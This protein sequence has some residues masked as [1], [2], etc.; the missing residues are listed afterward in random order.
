MHLDVAKGA[1]FNF[2]RG[3]VV[4]KMFRRASSPS[5]PYILYLKVGNYDYVTRLIVPTCQVPFRS[6]PQG[7]HVTGLPS[8][9]EVMSQSL[10]E[11]PMLQDMYRSASVDMS[12]W[13]RLQGTTNKKV[14]GRD[15]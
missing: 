2:K 9:P 5:C 1:R 8:G 6:G 3:V 13:W 7:L 10:D 12:R 11:V 4:A 15:D 14:S